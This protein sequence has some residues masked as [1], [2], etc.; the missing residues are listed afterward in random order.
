MKNLYVRFLNCAPVIAI[1]LSIV[2]FASFALSKV[3]AEE[4]P[5]RSVLRAQNLIIENQEIITETRE[6]HIQFMTA[7]DDNE[8]QV[9]RLREQCYEFDWV[10]MKV[11]KIE[12]CTPPDLLE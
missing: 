12:G 11:N 8:Y 2:I 1:S 5:S 9:R 4:A 10:G 3:K 6:A 7:K